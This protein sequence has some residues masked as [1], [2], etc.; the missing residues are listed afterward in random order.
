VTLR[1]RLS[2]FI[3]GMGSILDLGGTSMPR[4]RARRRS[5]ADDARNLA[6]DWQRVARDMQR[7]AAEHAA[8]VCAVN[9]HVAR[10]PVCGRPWERRCI[11]CGSMVP[12][13]G[14]Q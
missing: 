5:P 7:A 4:Y 12:T 3:A 10:G 1:S 8:E 2:A 13:G 9:G 11:R 14:A 6:A